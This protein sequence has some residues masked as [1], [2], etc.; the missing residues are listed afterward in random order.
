MAKKGTELVPIEIL[1]GVQPATDKTAVETQHYTYSDKIRFVD[2][3]ERK[4]GGFKS[5]IFDYSAEIDGTARSLYAETI[6]GKYYNVIGTN[7]KLYSLIGSTLTN[8]TPAQTASVAAANSIDTQYDTLGSNPLSA[9]SGSPVVTVADSDAARFEAGDTVYLSGATTFAG[10]PAINLNGDAIVRSVGSGTYTINVGVNATSTASGGG[11]SVVR[12]SGLITINSTAHGQENGDRVKVGGAADTGGILAAEINTEFSIRNSA[13]NSFD[14]M[15]IGEATSAVTGGGGSGVEFYKEITAGALNEGNVIGY[16]AGLYGI[17]LYGTALTSS[18]AR[19]YPRIWFMDRYG[20]TIIMNAGNQTGVYQW[21]GTNATA[22]ALVANAPTTVNYAFIS[23]NILVTFGEG[24]VENRV[25]GSDQGNIT[26]WT[27]SSVNQVFRDDIEGAGRLT[28]HAP[29]EDY[30]LIFTEN[31]TFKFRYIGLPFVWE[32]TELDA[33]I[34]I[35]APMA[36][37]S[38]KGVAFWMGQE[39]F[40]MYRGGTVEVIPANSQSESTLLRYVFGNINWGQKSKCF[41]WY[42]KRYNEVWFHYPSATSNE[43]DRVVVVNI[44]DYT[45]MPHTFSRTAAE[46]P[47]GKLK[48]PRMINVGDLY[49]HEIGF[50]ADDAAME[51]T[52]TSNNR[53]YGKENIN[54]NAIIPDSISSHD[55]SFLNVARLYPQSASPVYSETVTAT[56]TTERIPVINSGRFHQYTWSGAEL[57]QDWIKGSWFEEIQRGSP[58]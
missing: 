32:I 5:V 19:S 13:T 14:V 8:I 22:P 34:G 2:G 42:N 40:Y 47:N 58:E 28:S 21:D 50:D 12:S 6:N 38:A 24:N 15:T 36:R 39:N 54:V 4:I 3:T 33:T 45:W 52:L 7:E 43:C 35:I 41:A 18:S 26:N 51:F 10:I 16:G 23:N 27:S 57:G 17:G 49:Q 30:N 1:A 53:Y 44:L 37:V 31:K 11:G 56:P 48:N 29:L 20:D 25:T 9:V 55:V 46:Y